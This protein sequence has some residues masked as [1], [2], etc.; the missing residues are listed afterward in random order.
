MPSYRQDMAVF[1]MSQTKTKQEWS[2]ASVALRDAYTDFIL[3][4]QAMNC[5]ASTLEFYKYTAGKFLEWVEGRGVTRPEEV[6]A[7][8]VR[9]YIAELVSKGRKDTTVW[10]HARAVKTMLFFWHN[11]GYT[12]ALIK[13]E[14]PKLAKKRL[15]VLT[16]DEL[17]QIV[18]ECNVRDKAIILFMADSGLRRAE[19]CALNWSDVDMT[20]GLVRVKQGKGR[21]DRSAVIGATTRRALL[22]Y[23]R[24]LLQPDTK[25]PLFQTRTGARFTGSGLRC[26]FRRLT[27]RTGIHVTAH[28]M[29][30]TFTI[31][32][33]R[34]GMNALHLQN[35]GGWEDLQMVQHYA[36]MVD[37]DLL[38]EH[39][40]HS[41]I[42]GIL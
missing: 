27:K 42:D 25:S 36:Q 2:L 4:R 5:T 20:S 26:I 17:R 1:F 6:T 23:R 28:A 9:E 32:S 31:L 38:Q 16:A 41:P 7:R 40:A 10:D 34:A 15:P 11:E 29:R 33:L 21:K 19:V 13:F 14:L 35:L 18:K 3:S 22:A 12:P 30:R 37:D 8:Y 24:T 39:K